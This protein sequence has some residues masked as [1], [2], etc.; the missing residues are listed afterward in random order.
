[1]IPNNPILSISFR[2]AAVQQKSIQHFKFG[3]NSVSYLES[4][5]KCA[6]FMENV[7]VCNSVLHGVNACAVI[8]QLVPYEASSACHKLAKLRAQHVCQRGVL[9]GKAD[10][11]VMQSLANKEY[12]KY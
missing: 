6:L 10:P 2:F 3:N 9:R 4:K 7:S 11:G 1:L 12:F 8:K 5:N